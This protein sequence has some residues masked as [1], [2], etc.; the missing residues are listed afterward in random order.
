LVGEK[1]EV[2]AGDVVGIRDDVG[3]RV[4]TEV[5]TELGSSLGR[6]LGIKDG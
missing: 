6:E 3:P 4:G 1:D 5:G 2:G